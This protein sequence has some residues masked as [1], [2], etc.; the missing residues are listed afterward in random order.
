[1][2]MVLDSQDDFCDSIEVTYYTQLI[3]RVLPRDRGLEDGVSSTLPLAGVLALPFSP[4]MLLHMLLLRFH[5]F[6]VCYKIL[7]HQHEQNRNIIDVNLSPQKT[8]NRLKSSRPGKQ[9]CLQPSW[10]ALHMTK[11]WY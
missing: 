10:M 3:G 1:M 8:Y 5:F 11:S 7:L 2:F 4:G 9:E 6:V